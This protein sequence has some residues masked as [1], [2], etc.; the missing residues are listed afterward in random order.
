MRQCTARN[1][2]QGL[3][4]KGSKKQALKNLMQNRNAVYKIWNLQIRLKGY[5]AEC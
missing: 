4:S 1:E 3:G 2:V 5:F